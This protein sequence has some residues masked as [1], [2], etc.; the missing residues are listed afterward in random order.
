MRIGTTIK[1][2]KTKGTKPLKMKKPKQGKVEREIQSQGSYESFGVNGMDFGNTQRDR[3]S[4]RSDMD[5]YMRG[6]YK[7][8][9]NG[10]PVE[11]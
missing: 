2:K 4:V 1:R 5:R 11:P 10:I 3:D 9:I 8:K 7:N 6:N